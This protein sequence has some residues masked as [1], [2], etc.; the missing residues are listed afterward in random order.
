[1]LNG[2]GIPKP[3]LKRGQPRV[4]DRCRLSPLPHP[5]TFQFG[6]SLSLICTPW[7]LPPGPG[8][9]KTAV[10]QSD[11]AQT[12]VT[13]TLSHLFI[14]LEVCLCGGSSNSGR[15]PLNA[16]PKEPPN[17]SAMTQH[18]ECKNFPSAYLGHCFLAT[19]YLLYKSL[20]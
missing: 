12:G 7:G 11:F 10:L 2:R 18:G 4:S 5:Q 9:G 13:S 20:A 14:R 1:M 6:L 16:L 3:Q 19:L 17:F 8:Q 15:P